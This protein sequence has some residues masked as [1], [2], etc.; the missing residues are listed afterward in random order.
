MIENATGWK[1]PFFTFYIDQ[2]YSLL[3]DGTVQFAIIWW[4]TVETGS[5]IALTIASVVGLF[6]ATKKHR[7]GVF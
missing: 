6:P 5:A 4:I 3:S 2:A 1:N 7:K